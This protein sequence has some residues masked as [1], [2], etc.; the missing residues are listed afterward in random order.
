LL[1]R[2]QAIGYGLVFFGFAVCSHVFGIEA[3]QTRPVVRYALFALGSL[4]LIV[5]FTLDLCFKR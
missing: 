3:Y 2:Q 1:S 4:L 5:G